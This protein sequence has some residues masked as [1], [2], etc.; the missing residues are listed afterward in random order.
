M[1]KAALNYLASLP[2]RLIA[3]PVI[4]MCLA[5]FAVITPIICL[6]GEFTYKDKKINFL[7]FYSSF[8][9]KIR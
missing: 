5:G 8:R 1:S 7:D 6:I 2:L 4:L 9:K 3:I